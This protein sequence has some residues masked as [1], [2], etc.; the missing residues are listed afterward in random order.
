M[1]LLLFGAALLG[2]GITPMISVLGA[3][4]G[5]ESVNLLTPLVVPGTVGILASFYPA[6]APPAWDHIRW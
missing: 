4:E 5:L 6:T 2:D 3:M 1:L